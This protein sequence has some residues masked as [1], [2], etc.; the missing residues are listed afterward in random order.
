MHPLLCVSWRRSS[1]SFWSAVGINEFQVQQVR[2]Q[3]RDKLS[4]WHTHTHVFI[5]LL[6]VTLCKH[7]EHLLL[8]Q[9]VSWDI[10]TS[11]NLTHDS[12]AVWSVWWGFCL[13]LWLTENRRTVTC[14]RI[15]DKKAL[16]RKHK[17]DTHFL[18]PLVSHPILVGELS[19]SCSVDSFLSPVE[20]GCCTREAW[21]VPGSWGELLCRAREAPRALGW[22]LVPVLR[23]QGKELWTR[24]DIFWVIQ[25]SWLWT[26][27]RFL[28][29]WP[30]FSGGGSQG[31]S[32]EDLRNMYHL[33]FR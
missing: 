25:P 6:A 20:Q 23:E 13:F 28:G 17:G 11:G 14:W 1:P 22:A 26:R 33:K 21:A 3:A 12:W 29:R 19:F 32:L 5:M 18:S 15:C 16:S 4:F 9:T 24:G 2:S 27:K 8:K 10:K 30:S 7:C 31:N